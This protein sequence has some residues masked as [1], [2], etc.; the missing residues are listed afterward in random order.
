MQASLFAA[1]PDYSILPTEYPADCYVWVGRGRPHWRI[2]R[3]NVDRY[4]ATLQAS[5][6]PGHEPVSHDDGWVVVALLAAI[7]L[8]PA[9]VVVLIAT[10]LGG[11][12]I[13]VVA[14]LVAFVLTIAKLTSG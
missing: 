2:H 10:L 6:E 4:L 5:R 13:G 8:G 11:I 7:V 1:P 3:A 12:K 9:A 14:G